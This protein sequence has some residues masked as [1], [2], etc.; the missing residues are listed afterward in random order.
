MILLSLISKHGCSY[1]YAI[2]NAL[3]QMGEEVF[4][5]AKP[6]TVYPVLYRLEAEGL[7]RVLTDQCEESQR[8]KYEITDQGERALQNMI[9]IW[10]HYVSV[11]EH[12]L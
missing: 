8:K 4:R 11:V 3:D 1:G 5:N 9:G 2:I 6:G 7:I 12:F 10:K